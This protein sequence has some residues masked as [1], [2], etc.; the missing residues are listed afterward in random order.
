LAAGNAAPVGLALREDVRTRLGAGL[1]FQL[2]LLSDA[3][4]AEALRGHAGGRGFA[5]SPEIIDYLLRHGQ[6]DLPSLLT[7]L[8]ALDQYSLQTKR[9]ITLPLLREV[10]HPANTTPK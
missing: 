4:K 3:Q 2:R 10:L 9:P 1:V 5:L 7:V 8:D 6:R